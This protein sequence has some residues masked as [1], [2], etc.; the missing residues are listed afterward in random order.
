MVFNTLILRWLIW[1]VASRSPTQLRN[2]FSYLFVMRIFVKRHEVSSTSYWIYSSMLMWRCRNL[3]HC[4][5]VSYVWYTSI[6]IRNV[7]KI[8]NRYWMNWCRRVL[9]LD[10][11]WLKLTFMMFIRVYCKWKM[12]ILFLDPIWKT[13]WN[14]WLICRINET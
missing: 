13:F 11:K 6:W 5:V 3:K 14:L 2:I 12:K 9:D 4:L 1:K 10:W 7:W 8:W